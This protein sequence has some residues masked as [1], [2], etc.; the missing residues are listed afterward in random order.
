MTA[1]AELTRR[2][3][4]LYA[5]AFIQNLSLWYSIEKLFMR[6]IGFNDY[7][8]A[9]ATVVYVAVM[10]VT[11]VPLGVAADRWSRKGMLQLATC[12]LVASTLTCGLASGF[13]VYAAGYAA[14]GLFY[15]CCAGTY[16]AVVYDTVVEVTGC[17]DGYERWFGKVQQCTSAAFIL[18]AVASASL[19]HVASLRAQYLITA[20]VACCALPALSWFREPKLH[21]RQARPLARTHVWKLLRALAA[22]PGV[23]LTVTALT[24]DL[25]AIRVVEVFCQL[26][27]LGSSLPAALFGLSY[28]AVYAGSLCG[29]LAAARTRRTAAAAAAAV[30]AST[31]LLIRH[32]WVVVPAQVA[33][34]GALIV[35]Q[36]VLGGWLHDAVPSQQRTAAASI[37]STA[38]M[39]AFIPLALWFGRV[40]QGTGIFTA[41]WF[42]IGIT[43]TMAVTASAA[44]VLA[45]HQLARTPRS[46][47]ARRAAL[48]LELEVRAWHA[49]AGGAAAEADAQLAVPAASR[50]AR[51][52]GRSEAVGTGFRDAASCRP[53]RAAGHHLTL[54]LVAD[55]DLYS[56]GPGPDLKEHQ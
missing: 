35:L 50:A 1:E 51:R 33:L 10:V 23:A 38:G 29:G 40:A 21:R 54:Q 32:A 5:A 36:V 25:L 2:L 11:N 20:P 12:L 55:R 26:W 6:S 39:V 19:S 30:G 22:S 14:W 16:D 18:G 41:S 53:A 17:R 4:P 47:Q 8:I 13:A 27:W 56:G 48:T 43:C 52:P 15:V 28:A 46:S 42:L 37:P 3:R 45:R 9:L 7:T 49:G 44:G 24:C 31:C 34:L